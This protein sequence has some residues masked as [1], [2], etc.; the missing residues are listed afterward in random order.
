VLTVVLL[1]VWM[2]CLLNVISLAYVRLGFSTSAALLLCSSPRGQRYRH[3][4]EVREI[5]PAEGSRAGCSTSWS[6]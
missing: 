2:L 4:R 6:T 5:D 3:S 1:D